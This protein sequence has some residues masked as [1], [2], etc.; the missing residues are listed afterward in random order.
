MKSTLKGKTSF[1]GMP[2][3]VQI[4]IILP[5]YNLLFVMTMQSFLLSQQLK[6]I[7]Y[8]EADD[9]GIEDSGGTAVLGIIDHSNPAKCMG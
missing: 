1:L 3:F 9:P 5:V 4:N 6:L 2:C 8:A 7:S